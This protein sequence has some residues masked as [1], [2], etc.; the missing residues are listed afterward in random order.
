MKDLEKTRLIGKALT[1]NTSGGIEQNPE[2]LGED[3]GH[4]MGVSFASNLSDT[5]AANTTVS[6]SQDT[7]YPVKSVPLKLLQEESEQKRVVWFSENNHFKPNT[8][9]KVEI[10]TGIAIT[11]TNAKL[12]VV[13]HTL[14]KSC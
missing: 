9:F 14:V 10:T 6:I 1:L 11:T 7:K 8:E 13:Y 2:K 4:V 5:E 3:D 12:H